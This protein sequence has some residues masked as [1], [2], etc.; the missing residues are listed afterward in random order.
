MCKSMY[1]KEIILK[2]KIVL[3]ILWFLHFMSTFIDDFSHIFPQTQYALPYQKKNSV[4]KRKL[5][6]FF[7]DRLG[8]DSSI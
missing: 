2:V 5:H 7:N 6:K 8:V 4:S 3:N 1:D